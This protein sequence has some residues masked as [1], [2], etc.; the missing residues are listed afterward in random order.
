MKEIGNKLA[1]S[2]LDKI[3]EEYKNNIQEYNDVSEFLIKG[4]NRIND[5]HLLNYRIKDSEHLREKI[6]RKNKEDRNINL[7]NYKKEITDLIGIRLIHIFKDQWK[8]IDKYIR[9]NFNLI[10]QPIAYIR[11]GDQEESFYSENNFKLKYHDYGYRSLHYVLKKSEH[12]F[13]IIVE[14]QVRTIFEEAWSEIDY[15]VRYPNNTDNKIIEEYSMIINRLAGLG[16]EMGL[17]LK[18]LTETFNKQ[19]KEIND[20]INKLDIANK[21]KKQ[22]IQKI[23]IRNSLIASGALM[24]LLNSNKK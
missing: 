15:S 1:D 4:F 18:N 22:L 7:A 24:A 5:V 13:E 12:N 9:A 16:D 11:K 17:N 20:F 21:E 23:S 19:D 3:I 2:E 14:F 6:I 10:E 8:N